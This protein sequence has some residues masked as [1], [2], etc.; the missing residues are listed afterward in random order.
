MKDKVQPQ[1]NQ[2]PK[3][4]ESH[5]TEAGADRV[6][7]TLLRYI[8][9]GMMIVGG[10]EMTIQHVSEYGLRL[11]GRS[12]DDLVGLPAPLHAAAFRIFEADGETIPDPATM[13]LVRA[14]RHG[15]LVI[16]QEFVFETFDGRKIPVL[17]NAGPI[18]DEH[19]TVVGA[20]NAWRD[21]SRLKEVERKLREAEE[22][23]LAANAALARNSA[24]LAAIIDSMHDAVYVGD[25]S[26]I[27]RCNQVALEQLGVDAPSDLSRSVADLAETIQTRDA[28]SGKPLSTEEQ[29][30]V[31]ALGGERCVEE[32]SLIN[33]RTGQET[34][35]RCAAAPVKLDGDI[36]G[37]VA[38]NTDITERK[39]AERA[40]KESEERL[41]LAVS[42][43]RLG[44][45]EF[46]LVNNVGRWSSEAAAMHGL[47]SDKTTA[48]PE[49]W[50]RLIHPDDLEQVR[51]AFA[52][53]IRGGSDYSA[54]Y[55]I[56]R[57]DGAVRWTA[58]RGSVL[59]DA[60]GKATR[61][62]GL[63]RDITE[64]KK[65]DE[66]LAEEART[67]EVRVAE[68]TKELADANARLS[69]E[70]L[71]R[72]KAEAALLQ[73]Q[74]MEAIGLLTGGVAH[75]FNNLLTVIGGSLDM[76]E[77]LVGQDDR[78]RSHIAAAQTGTERGARLTSQLL[79]FARQ[80]ALHPETVYLNDL[81]HDLQELVG[82]A[83]GE[84]VETWFD[85]APEIWPCRVDSAQFQNAIL[86][87]AM[88]ARDAMANGGALR[89]TTRNVELG[90]PEVARMPDA[91]PGQYVAIILTDTGSGIAEDV[92]PKIFEPF[93]T[94]K[95]VGKG[96]GLGLSQVYGFVR[97]SGGTMVVDSKLGLGT[98]FKI[99]LPK[100]ESEV[101]AAAGKPAT[102]KAR[103]GNETIL[104][105]EDDEGVLA[106]V[107]ALL[108]GLG[109]RT[110]VARNGPEALGTLRRGEHVDLLF[111]DV[112][113]P[114]GING[115]DL[116]RE[117]RKLRP[118]LKVLLTTGYASRDL[119]SLVEAD[120][121]IPV[122]GKPYGR[123]ELAARI[124]AA[125]EQG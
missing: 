4:V 77:E 12:R 104:V 111:T 91:A 27:T 66:A 90:I 105:V 99:F 82:R 50:A 23:L 28:A 42:A 117:A 121:N 85:F 59:K 107:T 49:E 37:A 7:E 61:V 33:V 89:I 106:M 15:E 115:V 13:P 8:P 36:I 64:R 47:T 113:M 51:S 53:A 48:A 68:R 83:V 109:Y 125:L 44:T 123:T 25:L 31:R 24:E 11:V 52:R 97:Q 114:R 110:L 71:E 2:T 43:G 46:D 14:S 30:F 87:L 93:F 72:E 17:I 78:I 101:T 39:A 86:N 122:F 96:T 62:V 108:D 41:R 32:V 1:E 58:V 67:L 120:E 98:T 57:P 118:R 76:L 22:R 88:N 75:D 60:L 100:A 35:V 79:A 65:A 63:V 45:W 84:T 34:I 3:P 102:I 124:R 16:D 5:L 116:A 73:A 56:V 29:P 9:D 103:E 20:I 38:I 40:L 54:E 10:P 119:L 80:Q 18:R 81:L 92:L 6:V 112:V 19:G 70:I 21:V 55:R 74:R 95:D 94:T 26:G 69:G